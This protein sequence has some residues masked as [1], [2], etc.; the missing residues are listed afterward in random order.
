M[1]TVLNGVEITSFLFPYN[2][3]RAARHVVARL[4]NAIPLPKNPINRKTPKQS[5]RNAEIKARYIAGESAIHLAQEYS[6]TET[7]IYQILKDRR[8]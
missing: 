1:N 4:Y 6:I 3:D 8:K 5:D 2:I 7:R